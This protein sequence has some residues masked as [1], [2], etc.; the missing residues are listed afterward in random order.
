MRAA[1]ATVG[2]V[3]ETFE[4]GGVVRARMTAQVASRIAGD[5]VDMKVR[6]GDRIARGQVLVVLDSRELDA[7]RAQTRASLATATTAIASAGAA[8]E[9][10]DARL[11]LAR[12]THGR[13]AELRAKNSATP[14]E[15]DRAVADLRAAE[16]DVRAMAARH[17]EAR[18][19]EAAAEAAD[20]AADVQASFATVTAPFDGIATARL[21]EPGNLATPG[22]HLL[23]VETTDN[24][25]LEV[26][27]DERRARSLA[28]GDAVAVRLDSSGEEGTL[29][30]HVVEIARAIDPAG[31]AF[32]VKVQLPRGAAVRSGMFARATFSA[33]ERTGLLVPA[34]AILRRGQLSLVIVVDGES[35]ARTRAVD[36][37]LE[38]HGVREVLAGL[39]RGERVIAAPPASLVDGT[40]VRVASGGTP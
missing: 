35:R 8:L 36:V 11:Q 13:V 7:R 15:L 28:V 30:G 34:S 6:P 5:V 12:A 25:R 18:T 2:Q 20:R 22:A 40:R 1:F 37:G 32:L 3:V 14:Q 29:P 9:S 27:I 39:D 10:A 38:R 26:Q 19:A 31:H 16:A 23:T 17:D 33:G 21:M 4:A 24:Y